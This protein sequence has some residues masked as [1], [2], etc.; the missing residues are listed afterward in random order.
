MGVD[1][2]YKSYTVAN[3]A[4]NNTYTEIHKHNL[5]YEVESHSLLMKVCVCSDSG[6]LYLPVNM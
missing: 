3:I 5:Q 6:G 4:M 2:V 1:T